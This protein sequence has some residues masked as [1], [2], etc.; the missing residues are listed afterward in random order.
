MEHTKFQK[1]LI[2]MSKNDKNISNLIDKFEDPKDSIEFRPLITL[3]NFSFYADE[4]LLK[5]KK[6]VEEHNSWNLTEN[7]YE[8]VHAYFKNGWILMRK[9]LHDPMIPIN[10]ESDI[11]DG[12]KKIKLEVVNFLSQFENIQV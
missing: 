5:F 7:N 11:V 6:Y 8:G 2:Q 1:I 9:S 4:I 12:T 10:I 3:N